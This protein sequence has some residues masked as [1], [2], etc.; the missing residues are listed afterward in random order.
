MRAGIASLALLALAGCDTLDQDIG[1]NST[2]SLSHRLQAD[3]AYRKG[4]SA[5]GD[6]HRALS[7]TYLMGAERSHAEKVAE[8]GRTQVN[9]NVGPPQ[10]RLIEERGP[11]GLPLYDRKL[12]PDDEFM[13][14]VFPGGPN[15][16]KSDKLN[17]YWYVV[18]NK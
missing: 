9:V 6:V 11:G 17:R 18:N 13:G 2:L 14:T 7:D 5:K 10:A 16:Y 1:F 3:E 15:V 4:N 8:I 12:Y